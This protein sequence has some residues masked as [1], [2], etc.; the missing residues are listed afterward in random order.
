MF[1]RI[2]LKL[3]MAANRLYCRLMF[4]IVSPSAPPLPASGPALLVSDHSSLTDPV[5][6][7]ATAGRPIRFLMASEFYELHSLH[8]LFKLIGCIPVSRGSF[9]VHPVRAMLHALAQGNVVG[10]FP[11]GGIDEHRKEEGYEGIGFAALKSGAPVVPASIQWD[12][13]RPLT[14]LRALL[15]PARA[16]VRYGAPLVLGPATGR[17][18]DEAR[19]AT[20]RILQAIRE[21][22]M[23]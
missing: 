23:L 2:I 22:R 4:R 17:S 7:F 13:P 5:V 3:L 18:R 1:A 21:L 11:E 6:L 9:E 16:T 15:T 19:N 10:L 8:W 12:T 14:L 20:D